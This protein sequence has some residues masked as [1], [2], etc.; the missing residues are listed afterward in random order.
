MDIEQTI[1]N[2]IESV[3]SKS[4]VK[5]VFGEPYKEGGLTI[6]PVASICTRGGG[7]GGHKKMPDKEGSEADKGE[8]F[9]VGYQI[10]SRPVGYIQIKGEDARFV[11]I[12]DKSKM[13]L[14]GAMI[15]A[16]ILLLGGLI[17]KKHFKSGT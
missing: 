16:P 14:A 13:I 2:V 1:K 11:D 10:H 8:G 9:G 15:L 3:E 6:I 12:I 17:K 5:A 4:N 7:G